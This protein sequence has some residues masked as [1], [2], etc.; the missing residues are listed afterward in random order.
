[1]STSELIV[2]AV[3]TAVGLAVIAATTLEAL[4]G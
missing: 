3:A 4:L 2:I 1:M